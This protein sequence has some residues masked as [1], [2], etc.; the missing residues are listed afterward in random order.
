MFD[1]YSDPDSAVRETV[2]IIGTYRAIG[3]PRPGR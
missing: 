3:W 1:R 2:G